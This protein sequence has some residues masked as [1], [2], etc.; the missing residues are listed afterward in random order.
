MDLM[1]VLA[2]TAI[3]SFHLSKVFEKS[4]TAARYMESLS[5]EWLHLTRG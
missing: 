5:P 2:H 3:F 1:M 4:N